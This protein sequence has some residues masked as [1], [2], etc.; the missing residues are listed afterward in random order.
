M[1]NE[2]KTRERRSW[3]V[4]LEDAAGAR[5]VAR[6]EKRKDGRWRTGAVHVVGTGK[7][8]KVAR[9]ASAEHAD[10]A[11]AKEAPAKLV[12]A[13]EKAGGKRCEPRGGFASKPDVFTL[14]TLPK[15]KARK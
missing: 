8:K 13:A 5:L 2:I 15:P 14:E 3:A 7:S 10:E 4:Q 1:A 6:L 9:G 12:A 11:P